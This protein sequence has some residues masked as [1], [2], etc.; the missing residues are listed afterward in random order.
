MTGQIAAQVTVKRGQ[1]IKFATL[2]STKIHSM[3]IYRKSLII[4]LFLIPLWS[5]G[6]APMTLVPD[7]IL[8]KKYISTLSADEMEGRETGT[9]ERNWL[10]NIS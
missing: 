3:K 9:P 10:M 8:L 7:T 1:M 5:N 6:Q 4:I 2:N